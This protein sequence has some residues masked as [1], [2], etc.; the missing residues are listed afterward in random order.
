MLT[1]LIGSKS[2]QTDVSQVTDC[3]SFA[4]QGRGRWSAKLCV[5]LFIRSKKVPEVSSTQYD[6][7]C[8]DA[9]PFEFQ[10]QPP[11]IAS[12]TG[13]HVGCLR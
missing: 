1:Y 13:A 5:C 8:L 4:G 12:T 2:D 9:A 10:I 6:G 3:L 7:S 11:R